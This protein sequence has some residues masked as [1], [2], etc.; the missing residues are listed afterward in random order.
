[1]HFKR[2]V[3]AAGEDMIESAIKVAI[4]GTLRVRTKDLEF[5]LAMIDAQKIEIAGMEIA[6]CVSEEEKKKFGYEKRTDKI[7]LKARANFDG[8]LPLFFCYKTLHNLSKQTIYTLI[9][10]KR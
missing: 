8:E 6:T 4:R 9:V 10:V 3:T 7:K 1:M 5:A 2:I